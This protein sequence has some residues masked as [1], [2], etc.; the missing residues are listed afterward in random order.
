MVTFCCNMH[1]QGSLSPARQ[2]RCPHQS[3][4]HFLAA[5]QHHSAVHQTLELAAQLLHR[6][7]EADQMHWPPACL[8]SFWEQVLVPPLHLC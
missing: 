2:V 7:L 4:H 6:C 3:Q 8:L 1:A 5:R